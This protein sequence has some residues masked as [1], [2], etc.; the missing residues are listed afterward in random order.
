MSPSQEGLRHFF[1][2][3]SFSRLATELNS[4]FPFYTRV[5]IRLPGK[6]C[7]EA[8]V[9]RAD[10]HS[11]TASGLGFALRSTLLTD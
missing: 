3:T 7:L 6:S 5:S 8:K 10:S 1:A 2:F 11:S 9:I 4:G